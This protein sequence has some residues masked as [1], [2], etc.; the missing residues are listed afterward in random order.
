[1]DAALAIAQ[2]QRSAARVP[3][4]AHGVKDDRRAHGRM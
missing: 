2:A 3:R 1:M 4:S